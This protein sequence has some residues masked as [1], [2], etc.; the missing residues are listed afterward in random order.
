MK[1]S[2]ALLTASLTLAVGGAARA[3]DWQIDTAHTTAQFS[4][5]HMMVSTVRGQFEKVS[6]TVTLDDADPTRSTIEVVIDAATINTREPKRDAHLKSPDFF[7]VAKNPTITFKST[8]IEKAGKGYKATGD[9]TMH[10]VTHP[11]TLLVEALAPA[12]KAPWGPM[13]RGVAASGKL[14][15]KEWGLNW[16]KAL[17]AGGVMV[18]DE[19]QLQIDAELVAKAPA[20]AAK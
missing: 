13:V 16:N 4:V 1:S 2:I 12:V 18:S 5:R 3:S 17:E 8:R 11:V 15:R 20:S 19:V 6:G 14:S 7:D 9:L 10:G